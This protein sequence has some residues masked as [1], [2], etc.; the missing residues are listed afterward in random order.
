MQY[1]PNRTSHRGHDHCGLERMIIGRTEVK[2]NIWTFLQEKL[3]IDNLERRI[4]SVEERLELI[5]SE[6]RKVQ[7]NLSEFHSF[8]DRTRPELDRMGSEIE[9][10]IGSIDYLIRFNENQQDVSEARR[11]LRRLK[12]IRTRIQ[13]ASKTAA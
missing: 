8:K 6:I 1:N 12:N 2:V 3:G 5:E 10:I 13:N 9:R 4:K 7:A 11:L